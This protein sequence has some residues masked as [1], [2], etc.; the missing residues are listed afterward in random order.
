MVIPVPVYPLGELFP[1]LHP[2]MGRNFLISPPNKG[3]SRGESGIGSPLPS[4][5]SCLGTIGRVM[6]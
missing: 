3:I 6:P 1:R 4:L 2:H 5:V